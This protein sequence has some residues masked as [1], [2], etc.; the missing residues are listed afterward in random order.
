MNSGH[1]QASENQNPSANGQSALSAEG[2]E[3]SYTIP[4]QRLAPTQKVSEVRCSFC[5]VA[6]ALLTSGRFEECLIEANEP[7]YAD[8]QTTN[9]ILW[10]YWHLYPEPKAMRSYCQIPQ[11]V[12]MPELCESQSPACKSHEKGWRKHFKE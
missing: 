10:H 6:D 5:F 11:G 8:D 4:T 9:P 12:L 1:L 2:G 7:E 3:Q